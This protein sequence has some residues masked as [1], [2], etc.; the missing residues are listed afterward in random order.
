MG[1]LLSMFIIEGVYG[2]RRH[3]LDHGLMDG[4]HL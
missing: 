2:H 4:V 1:P 3:G